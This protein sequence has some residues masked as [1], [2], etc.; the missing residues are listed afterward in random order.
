M[1]A[2][3]IPALYKYSIRPVQVT[4][5][6]APTLLNPLTLRFRTHQAYADWLETQFRAGPWFKD[7]DRDPGRN[8]QRREDHRERNPGARVNYV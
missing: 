3:E 4:P 1:A 6:G 7:K 8:E 2:F 5:G